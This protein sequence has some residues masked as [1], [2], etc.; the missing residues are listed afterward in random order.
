MAS[1]RCS[2]FMICLLLTCFAAVP[3]CASVEVSGL[4]D[5][6]APAVGRSISAVWSE[7]PDSPGIDRVHTLSVVAERLFAGY[8]ADISLADGGALIRFTPRDTVKWEAELQLPEL[9]GKAAEWF[10]HDVSGLD[11]EI[12][13]LLSGLPVD[14]L[15]WA[16]GA[17]RDRI[18]HIVMDRLPGWGFAVRVSVGDNSGL[19]TLSFRPETPLVLAAVPSLHSRTIPVM[20]QSDLEAKLLTGLSLL[21][22]L[23]VDWT[24]L[25]RKDIEVLARE[26][27]EDRNSVGNMRAE[28][29]VSFTPGT[30]SNADIGVESD[31]F[32]FS[33]WISAY[34]GFK[35]RYPEAGAFF[36]WNMR[37]VT[38]FDIELYDEIIIDLDDFGLVNRAGLRFPLFGGIWLGAEAEWPEGYVYGRLLW[39]SYMVRRPYLWWR[40]NPDTGHEGALGYRVSDHISVE[41]YYDGRED[42]R[43]GIRGL[44]SL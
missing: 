36:G 6:L 35:G 11:S 44:L 26:F 32:M 4:P 24:E 22:G 23:P 20:F 10:S 18:E 43:M 15:S 13:S 37:N 5:W 9:R 33:V 34:A 40:W 25:H 17:L 1:V 14:A 39:D 31:R 7:I 8:D 16:D 29:S 2:K 21:I 27:L 12:S 42:S 30:I 38:G 28:V 19:L 41:L 3:C